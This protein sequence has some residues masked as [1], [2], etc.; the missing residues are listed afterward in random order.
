MTN[1]KIYICKT[2]LKGIKLQSQHTTNT[3]MPLALLSNSYKTV[4]PSTIHI[5]LIKK[6]YLSLSGTTPP[7]YKILKL[8]ILYP[9]YFARENTGFSHLHVTLCHRVPL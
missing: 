3:Q 4:K 1:D 6:E 2:V 8:T 5:K 9:V 7:K